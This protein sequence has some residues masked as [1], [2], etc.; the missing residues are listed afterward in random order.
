MKIDITQEQNIHDYLDS[1]I[2]LIY[3]SNGY[4]IVAK[5][6]NNKK[7]VSAL[8]HNWIPAIIYDKFPSE[9]HQAHFEIGQS[10]VKNK[11]NEINKGKK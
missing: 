2:M 3:K 11:I 8:I 10:W 9:N 1:V 5:D 7:I 4:C 6:E